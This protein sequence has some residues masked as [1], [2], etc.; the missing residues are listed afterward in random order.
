MASLG[1][2]AGASATSTQRLISELANF[3]ARA[4]GVLSGSGAESLAAEE[5]VSLESDVNPA[6]YQAQMRVLGTA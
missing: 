2:I 4:R 5:L 1:F 6:F 3:G